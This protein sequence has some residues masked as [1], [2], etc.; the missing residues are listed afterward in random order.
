VKERRR[1][2]GG[3]LPVGW[4]V[5]DV[6]QWPGVHGTDAEVVYNP[7]RHQVMVTQGLDPESAA[8]L[9]ADGWQRHATDGDRVLW[10]RDRVAVTQAALARLD[11]AAAIDPPVAGLRP[12]LALER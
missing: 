2:P 9:Q 5:E 12:S 1:S 6:G 3:P 11:Q 10:T 4:I 7:R 8:A